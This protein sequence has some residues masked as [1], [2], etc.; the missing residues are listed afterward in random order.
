MAI[1]KITIDNV[2]GGWQPS[3]YAGEKGQF[4]SS[5]A[6][7][8]DVP[9]TDGSTDLKTAGV[10]RPVAYEKFSS[11]NVNALPIAI[12]T[13]PKNTNVYVVLTNGRLISYNSSLGSETLV[14]TVTG[15]VAHGACYYNN[16]IY[17]FG[18]G[19]SQNDV[20]RYGPL[21]NSP[22]LANGVW[23]GAT[24]GSQTALVDTTYPTTRHSTEY[25]N[26]YAHVH[27]DNKA[28]FC[29]FS[30]GQG[31]IHY[32]KTSKTTD[33]GDTNDG[34]THDALDLPFGWY[35]YA[36]ESYGND[37]V[38]AATQVTDSSVRQGSSALFFWD[39]TSSSFSQIVPIP[40]PFCTALKFANG[41][42]YGLSGTTQGGV[43]LFRYLGGNTIQTLS[44]I[45]DGHPPMQ[46]A[47]EAFG[48]RI[49]WG[50]FTTDIAN[51]ASVFAYGSKSD[52]FPRGVHNI[53]RSTVTATSSNGLIGAF[54]N[55]EQGATFPKLLIAGTDGTNYNIDKKSTTYQ[56]HIWRSKVYN[57]GRSF[58]VTNVSLRLGAD[59]ATNMTLV[60]KL[61]F[62][63]EDASQAGTT[64]NSTNYDASQRF[65]TME[66]T[67]FSGA[68]SGK[69]NF[70]L[71][72]TWSGTALLPVWL[73][74]EITIEVDD[75]NTQ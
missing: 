32:I 51:S 39:T 37:L 21:N 31:L 67:N 74:I 42:L 71:E 4:L 29:D 18:T 5:V 68:V 15:S 9:L 62:D 58:K 55:F 65:I 60:P 36:I 41:V 22:S 6:I 66:A 59:V 23:T 50:S 57:V 53:A 69:Q 17:I 38:I 73:P 64:I 46:G 61:F 35:P 34:S 52:L 20:S 40:D 8:P 2:F 26:H 19:A 48:N 11:T 7:D 72:L 43:R 33:E 44:Y 1:Q 16:Y 47:I 28:Y 45:A 63:N 56:T 75:L 54:K 70:F 49:M 12:I 3:T 30:N 10:L 25:L 14:G 27:V 24:L 13:N